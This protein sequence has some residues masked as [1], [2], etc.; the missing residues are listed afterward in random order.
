LTRVAEYNKII[1]DAAAARNIPVADV[2]GLFDRVTSTAGEQ[3]GPIN[4]NGAFVTGGFF[5]FDGF[6]LTDL[7]YLMMGNEFIKAINASYH[8]QIPLASITQLFDNNGGFFPD[9]KPAVTGPVSFSAPNMGMTD[10]ALR[11][12]TEFWAQPTVRRLRAVG[13]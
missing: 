3:L 13:H 6:H 9:P 11:E 5:S 7:G 4:V 12:I 10:E 2:K 8:T 1:Q